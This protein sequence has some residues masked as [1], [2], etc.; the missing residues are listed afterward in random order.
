VYDEDDM[1]LARIGGAEEV[2][3][4]ERPGVDWGSVDA[5]DV[6]EMVFALERNAAS[7]HR[8]LA[9][10]MTMVN[11]KCFHECGDAASSLAVLV[12]GE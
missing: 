7:W 8:S 10:L 4:D 6:V 11:G 12:S 5:D 1:P 9:A 3:V 2:L